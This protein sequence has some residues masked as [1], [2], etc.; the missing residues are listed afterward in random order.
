MDNQVQQL[1][2]IDVTLVLPNAKSPGIEILADLESRD[3]GRLT[4]LASVSS[5]KGR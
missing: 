5:M 1:T 2:E 4:C 3:D